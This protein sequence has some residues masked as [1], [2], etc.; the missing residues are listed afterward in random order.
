M[1]ELLEE[2]IDALFIITLHEYTKKNALTAALIQALYSTLTR[3][4]SNPD[5]RFILLKA[6]GTCFCAGADLQEMRDSLQYSAEENYTDAY[7]LAVLLQTIY[8][9]PKPIVAQVQG[10]VY[11]GGIGL[12]AACDIV[13]AAQSAQFCLS[14]VKLGLVPAVISPYLL[15]AI[16][17]H[18]AR[19]LTISAESIDCQRAQAIGLVHHC[20]V[21]RTLTAY[22]EAYMNRL[23]SSAP[24]AIAASKVLLDLVSTAHYDEALIQNTAQCIAQKRVS[25]EGQ[26]GLTAFLSK[27]KPYWDKKSDV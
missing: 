3:A 13:I 27:N 2:Q 12:I 10:S 5:I 22:T 17:I 1:A 11:G 8:T 23:Y 15:R 6:E 9:S 14:E 4:I 16:G 18:H 24:Q 19:W 21:D 20:I 7:R 26:A 25:D